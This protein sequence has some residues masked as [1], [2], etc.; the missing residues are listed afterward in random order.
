MS[1]FNVQATRVLA[2]ANHPEADRLDLVTVHGYTSIVA[3]DQFAVGDL[4]V[5]LPEAA[6]LP[7]YLIERL[8]LVGKLAGSKHDRVKAVRLRG[9]FSQ[10]ICMGVRGETQA[11]TL[12]NAN[13]ESRQFAEGEDAAEF[14]GIT[15][16]EPP[17][18]THLAGEVANAGTHL[19]VAFD[20]ENIKR[21]PD[22]LADG[23]EV[24]FTE[25]LHGTF[26]GVGIVPEKDARDEFVRGRFVVFSKGLGGQGLVFKD[27]AA[28]ASNAYLRMAKGTGLLD[29]MTAQFATEAEPVFFLGETFGKVQD[30]EYGI[31]GLSFRAF[32]MVRGYRGNQRYE[33]ND[34][35]EAILK[36]M[37]VARVPVVYRGPFSQEA[38]MEHTRGKETVSGQALHIREGVVVTP[39]KERVDMGIGRVCLKSISEDYLLRKDKNATEFT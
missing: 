31:K 15:K 38:L 36:T 26:T 16:F 27:N 9:I 18:P 28:N 2:V 14:L 24:V 8:G 21:F 11:V 32:A 3:R 37:G 13:G 7:D 29:A 19:T 12:I 20:I 34:A 30:L 1:T 23:E 35:F 17:V 5:Y 6:V 33:D 4:V 22:V 10:G 25:K 39:V